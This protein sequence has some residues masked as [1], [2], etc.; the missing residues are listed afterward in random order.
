MNQLI[1]QTQNQHLMST[2]QIKENLH[3]QIE[4]VDDRFLRVMSVMATAYLKEQEDAALEAEINAIPPNPDWKPMTEEQ[5]MARLAEGSAQIERGEYSTIE[6]V[7]KEA[8]L[9]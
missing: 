9:W 6:E 8:E 1:Y 4:Q 3:R 7:R 5:L 2:A